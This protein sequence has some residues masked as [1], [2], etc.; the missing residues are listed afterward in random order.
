MRTAIVIIAWNSGR[1]L[2]D[3]VASIRRHVPAGERDIVIVDNAS[4]DTSYLSVYQDSPDVRVILSPENLGYARAANLGL[5]QSD[6]EYCLILN[7]DILFQNNPFPRLAS[8]LDKDSLLGAVG[9]LLRDV[10]GVPQIKGYYRK[11]PNPL[12]LVLNDTVFSRLTWVRRLGE[13]LSHARIARTGTQYV[14]QI[15][16]AFLFFKRD[17]FQPGHWMNEAYFIWM[18]DVD[19]CRQLWKAGRRVAVVADESVTHLGGISFQ[20]RTDLWK[21]RAFTRSYLTYLDLNAARPTRWLSKGL[22]ATDTLIRLAGRWLKS[23][24]RAARRTAVS[25]ETGILKLILSGSPR[26]V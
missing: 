11:F 3:C 19:F 13:E 17:S 1:V 25:E 7:P 6:A 24:G 9:P 26:R 2:H 18:E 10:H 5:K 14:D 12:N 4:A 8:A 22:M 16:G 15:P 23:R 20:L 21:R